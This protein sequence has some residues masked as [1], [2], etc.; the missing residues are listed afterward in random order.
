MSPISAKLLASEPI[1]L[2]SPLG[3]YNP[4][5]DIM[6]VTIPTRQEAS[7]LE[8]QVAMQQ[9][10]IDIS[11]GFIH[12]PSG[13]LNLGIQKA[14]GR[15]GKFF[16]VD[17][18]HVVFYDFSKNE[19]HTRHEWCSRGIKSGLNKTAPIPIDAIL[20]MVS[21]HFQGEFHFVHDTKEMA[22]GMSRDF[23]MAQGIQ[24]YLTVPMMLQS[25]CIGFIGLDSVQAVRNFTPVEIHT[26]SFFADIVVNIMSRIEGEKRLQKLLHMTNLQNQRFRD[27][28][29][30]TSHNIRSSAVNLVLISDYLQHY[31]GDEKYTH[32]L[33]TTVDKLNKSIL[34]ANNLLNFESSLEAD[35]MA[36]CKVLDSINRVLKWHEPTIFKKGISIQNLVSQDLMVT[37][38]PSYLD[39]IFNHVISNA[40]RHGVTKTA[41]NITIDTSNINETSVIRVIDQGKGIDLTKYS[42]KLFK[43]GARFHTENCDMLGMGLFIVKYQ[44]EAMGG[45]VEINSEVDNGTV[46]ELSFPK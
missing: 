46:V 38:Y 14:L 40:I 18:V 25:D 7:H 5:Y 24:S 22:G 39:S 12:L 21:S 34:N 6:G 27:F 16:E 29:Y 41:N 13:Q 9:M 28:S 26:L 11:S 42:D 43:I 30:I 19:C 36:P 37:S 44:M 17:R 3:T 23:L 33:K 8:Y 31:P 32:Q 15:I 10:I 2:P 1:G 35:E 4:N 45:K 20:D